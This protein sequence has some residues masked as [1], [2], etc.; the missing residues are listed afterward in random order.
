MA[1]PKLNRAMLDR[2]PI[3][4]PSLLEQHRI[5]ACLSSL[6]ELITAE[7][8]KLEGLKKHKRGLMQQLFPSAVEA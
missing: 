8:Q 4:F 7:G 1:Q 6:D 3:P 2:I 5:A